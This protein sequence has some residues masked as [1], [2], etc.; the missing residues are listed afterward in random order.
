MH[1]MI[2]AIGISYCV[3]PQRG[4][5]VQYVHTKHLTSDVLK[6]LQKLILTN[7][8][9]MLQDGNIFSQSLL[10][11]LHLG[12]DDITR[13]EEYVQFPREQW[14]LEIPSPHFLQDIL[15]MQD[16]MGLDQPTLSANHD[17]T[18]KL[19]T[20]T[21]EPSTTSVVAVKSL[22]TRKMLPLSTCVVC[23]YICMFILAFL[24][25]NTIVI[26][27]FLSFSFTVLQRRRP[28]RLSPR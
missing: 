5:P 12:S 2:Q 1:G 26:R 11:F 4:L 8:N 14:Y 15:A 17:K 6:T 18:Q 16:G 28:G 13:V 22:M 20:A 21:K 9:G 7:F 24:S 3:L 27:T 10:Y 23:M 25:H 19:L